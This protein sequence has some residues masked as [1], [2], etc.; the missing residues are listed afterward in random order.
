MVKELITEYTQQLSRDL[1]FQDL[2]KEL[3]DISEKYTAPNGELLVAIDEEDIV[4]GMVAYYQHSDTRCEMKRLYVRPVGCGHALGDCLIESIMEHAKASGYKEIVLDTIEPLKAAIH[5]YKK[6]DFVE[7]EP[8]Y[9]NPLD[10][11]IY[12]SRALG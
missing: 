3:V 7:C 12:M 1:S 2:D 4:L 10:D 6:H 8:Y 11:V 9:H 5:L